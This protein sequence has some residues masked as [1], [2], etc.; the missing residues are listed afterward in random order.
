MVI[1]FTPFLYFNVLT[2][3]LH[4]RITESA[5]ENR[6]IIILILLI[7]N[8]HNI[9]IIITSVVLSGLVLA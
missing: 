5:R 2:Q 9:L 8:N 3:Q 7:N 4:E 1:Q 6:M